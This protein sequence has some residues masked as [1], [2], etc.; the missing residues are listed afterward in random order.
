MII[1][2]IKNNDQSKSSGIAF[3]F[4]ACADDLDSNVNECTYFST[5]LSEI[6]TV[7]VTN[8]FVVRLLQFRPMAH[9]TV[10]ERCMLS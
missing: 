6:L 7:T 1:Y 5:I 3:S 8:A 9:S 10:N 2:L 4:K